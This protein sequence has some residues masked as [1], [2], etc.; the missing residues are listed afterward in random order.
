MLGAFVGI[1]GW[2]AKLL[3]PYGLSPCKLR[4]F[5]VQHGLRYSAGREALGLKLLF[6]A[7]IAQF[8]GAMVENGRQD[9]GF[10]DETFGLEVVEGLCQLAWH[11]LVRGQFANQLSP[12]VFALRQKPQ[13][14]SFEGQLKPGLSH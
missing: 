10:V 4:V 7:P 5:Q 6:N 11:L 3:L 8:G 13:R 9:A 12:R 1:G 14:T 2:R